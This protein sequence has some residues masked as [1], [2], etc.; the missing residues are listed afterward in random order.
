MASGVSGRR[1][2]MY[3]IFGVTVSLVFLL[4]CFLSVFLSFSLSLFLS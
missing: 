4:P 2:S 1:P 3:K